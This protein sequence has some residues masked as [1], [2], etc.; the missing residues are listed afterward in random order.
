MAKVMSVT[1]KTVLQRLCLLSCSLLLAYHLMKASL[2]VVSCPLERHRGQE[3]PPSNI[4]Q[5]TK[6]LGLIV[7][8]KLSLA[9]T[10]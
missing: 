7:Q 9:N 1:F 6:V 4:L 8:E 2:H 3:R 10:T 5:G